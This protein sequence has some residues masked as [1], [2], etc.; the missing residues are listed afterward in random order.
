VSTFFDIKPFFCYYL[1][2]GIL[3][4]GVVATLISLFALPLGK[5]TLF[6]IA[7]VIWTLVGPSLVALIVASVT[8]HGWRLKHMNAALLSGHLLRYVALVSVSYLWMPFLA[9]PALIVCLID[10]Y[11]LKESNKILTDSQG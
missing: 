10:S 9:V 4:L 6:G 1:P 11:F 3:I 5:A 7:V 8:P 2:M